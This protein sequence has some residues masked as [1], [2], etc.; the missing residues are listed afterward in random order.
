MLIL[1]A[2]A[3]PVVAR[4][5]E[6]LGVECLHGV[7]AKGE[8]LADWAASR[9]IR[10]ERIAY[11]GNDRNDLPALELVGW[12]IA[13]RDAVP[14]VLVAARHVLDRT[15]GHGA[16]REIADLILTSRELAARRADHREH[17]TA[18]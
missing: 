8:A 1:S 13:V 10:L 18:R 12:P 14:D 7:D 4:R 6:K 2:E 16:V 17:A 15:G 5:A 9:G 11:V 3:N